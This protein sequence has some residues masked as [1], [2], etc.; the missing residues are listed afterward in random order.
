V[1]SYK[2]LIF[3]NFSIIFFLFRILKQK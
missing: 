2:F 3:T 1:I